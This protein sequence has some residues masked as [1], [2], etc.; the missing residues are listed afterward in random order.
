MY[1]VEIK[2]MDMNYAGCGQI[3][4]GFDAIFI[5]SNAYLGYVAECEGDSFTRQG[6]INKLIKLLAT[7]DDPNDFNI[8]CAIYDEVGIDSDTFTEEE[9]SYIENKVGDLLK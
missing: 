7:S 2:Y 9:I 5:A 6:K 8:Q 1:G 3:H 4:H